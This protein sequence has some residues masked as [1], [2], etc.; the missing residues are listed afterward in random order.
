M[1]RLVQLNN[2]NKIKHIISRKCNDKF[3]LHKSV[4]NTSETLQILNRNRTFLIWS[5]IWTL[6]SSVTIGMAAA[7]VVLLDAGWSSLVNGGSP[8]SLGKIQIFKHHFQFVLLTADGMHVKMH[9]H[10]IMHMHAHISLH[11][12]TS[13]CKHMHAR[14]HAHT[15]T[16]MHAHTPT[17]AHTH[18]AFVSYNFHFGN[19]QQQLYTSSI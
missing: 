13:A 9:K 12:L 4:Y 15:H 5:C 11:A 10:N 8:A 16:C 3:P 2:K 19:R 18:T 1:G 14:M 17:R 7:S 6:S